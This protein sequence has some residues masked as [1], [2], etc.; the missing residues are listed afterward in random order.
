MILKVWKVKKKKKKIHK[1]SDIQCDPTVDERVCLFFFRSCPQW[2]KFHLI[3]S[4]TTLLSPFCP[5]LVTTSTY[6]SFFPQSLCLLLR[7]S[8]LVQTCHTVTTS[9]SH[10]SPFFVVS[11]LIILFFFNLFVTWLSKLQTGE[12]DWWVF[13]ICMVRMDNKALGFRK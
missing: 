1:T 10:M 12:S 6:Q 9:S 13:D 11:F 3:L 8:F 2:V 5:P 4:F 7:D